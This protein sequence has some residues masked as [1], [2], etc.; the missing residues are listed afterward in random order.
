MNR[1]HNQHAGQGPVRVGLIADADGVE[2]LRGPLEACVLLHPLAQA[3]MGAAPL[4]ADVQVFDD[5]RALLAESSLEA[6]LLACSTRENLAL[7]EAA[8]EHGLHVWR[9]PPVGRSFA[10]GTECVA[11]IRQREP[12]YRV[13]S[14]WEYVADHVWHEMSWPAEFEPR[15]TEISAS[16]AGPTIASWRAGL[17]DAAGGALVDCGYAALE[18]L[19]AV[20]GLPESVVSAVGHYR[21]LPGSVPREAEDTAIAIL[22]Y[23]NGG[24]AVVRATWDLPPAELRTVHHSPGATATLTSEEVQLV[25]AA[26]KP[27]D[28]RPLPGDFLAHE[29]L[30]FAEMVRSHARDRALAPLDRH[31][32]ASALLDAVYL[33]ARTGHPESPRKLYEVQKW[34]EPRN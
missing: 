1:T 28:R 24:M 19:V 21:N 15:L 14:W 25:D 11:R 20:R 18:A 13:A 34:P 23:S 12:L 10:E 2:L 4:L 6:V 33:S 31:L 26:G 3:R 22:R 32:A 7:A 29:L 5:A 16:G 27:L 30:R 9:P 17:A 8:G